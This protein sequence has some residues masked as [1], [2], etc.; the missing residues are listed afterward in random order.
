MSHT[1]NTKLI[2]EI[3]EAWA[4]ANGY[5]APSLKLRSSFVESTKHQANPDKRRKL[6]AP[7][8]KLQA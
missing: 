4:R 6:Q 3:H 7:S 1:P 2:H 8:Y 5:R